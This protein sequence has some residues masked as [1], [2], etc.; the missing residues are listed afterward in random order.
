MF[1]NIF[2]LALVCLPLFLNCAGHRQAENNAQSSS[3]HHLIPVYRTGF[4]VR[5][6]KDGLLIDA[7]DADSTAKAAGIQKGDLIVSINGKAPSNKEFLK[8]MH[9]NRGEDILFKI[10]RYGQILGDYIITPKLYFNSPPSAYKIYE[11]S[12]IDEQRVNL[13]VIVTEVRNYTSER[14]YLWEES[15]RHQVQGDIEN[16]MLNNLDRQDRLSFVDRSRLD[17]IID[18]Y[19][20]NMTGLASDD[21]RAEISKTTGATHLLVATFARNPKRIKDRESCEDTITGKLIDIKSGRVLAVDQ[22]TSVCRQLF[23]NMIRNQ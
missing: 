19:K 8:L 16:N 11:L 3:A 12:V 5:E 13:A 20:L 1:N 21:A 10:E 4:D 14:N 18:G 22:N 15:M 9:T 17:K 2:F 23:V 6:V 7:F